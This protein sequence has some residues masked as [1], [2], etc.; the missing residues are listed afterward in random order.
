MRYVTNSLTLIFSFFIIFWEEMKIS[1]YRLQIIG[2]GI[3]A[4]FFINFLR[5]KYKK[6]NFINS[7]D[8]FI[9]NTIVILLV[10]ATGNASSPVFFLVYFL[11]FGITFV[12]EPIIVFLFAIGIACIFLPGAIT[13]QSTESIIKIGSIFFIAPL[14]FFF[15]REYKNREKIKNEAEKISKEI[16]SVIKTEDTLSEES[17]EN[18]S[19]ALKNANKI[20]KN[21]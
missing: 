1:E 14:A 8:I 21:I 13:N 18:L 20:K 11:S 15:G 10:I 3:L 4:Y 7:S 5:R 6:E 17:L 19:A 12:F 2:L 16:N 9:V